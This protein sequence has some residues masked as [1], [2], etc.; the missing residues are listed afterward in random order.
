M[1][2]KKRVIK[3]AKV[4]ANNKKIGKV[5]NQALL[6]AY[7]AGKNG[8]ILPSAKTLYKKAWKSA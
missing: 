6:L 8:D 5:Q 4:K 7:R 2:K 1:A 3:S